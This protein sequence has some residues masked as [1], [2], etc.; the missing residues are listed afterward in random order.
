MKRFILTGLCG[1]SLVAAC[2]FA[3]NL[4]TNVSTCGNGGFINVKI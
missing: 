1:L 3:S 2:A 4:D